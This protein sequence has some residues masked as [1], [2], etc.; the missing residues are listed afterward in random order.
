MKL[1]D[2]LKDLDTREIRAD[3]SLEIRSV[4]SDSRKLRQGDVFVC[5]K[6]T[7]VDGTSF[8]PSA[9]ERGAAA[10]V[11][12][13][14]PKEKIPYVLM[15]DTRDALPRL[16]SN[17]YGHPER[18]F[19]RIIGITGTNGKT[20]T[21]FMLKAIFDHAGHKTGLIGTTKYLVL[22][23]EFQV[24]QKAAFLTT[25][26]PELLFEL[27]C[28]MREK[29]VD[30]VIMETSSHALA[31]QKLAGIPFHVGIFTNL[32]RDHIDFH[33]TMEEYLQAKKLLFKT[34]EKG[35]FNKDDPAFEAIT[36]NVRSEVFSFSSEK[37]AHFKA[38]RILSHTPHGL[39]FELESPEGK[40][41]I[42]LP[43]P[44]LFNI[45]NALCAL[46]GASL[47][48]IPV[49]TAK[50]ALAHMAGV[51]GRI[52]R[53]PTDT[54]FSVFID[55]AHTPD[56]LENIIKT[57]RSFTEGRLMVLFGCGGDRD[58]TKRP[59]MGEIACRLSDFVIV[60]SDNSRTEKK[61]DIIRDILVG[62]EGTKTPLVSI[63]DRTAAI[64][65]AIDEAREGDVILLAGKGH[66]E[67]EIDEN[68]KHDYSEK[69]IVL[70]YIGEK[71]L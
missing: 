46:G 9:L 14:A 18:S 20:T 7:R 5:L 44:G 61:E 35:L 23:E 40:E 26:D 57:L 50:E 45:S 49:K 34:A 69:A 59:I 2:L 68:G 67:Y 48:G 60:T 15:E 58:K 33:Q 19:D 70:E 56:A 42:S 31:L 65:F 38:G 25:P 24:D 41:E 30:T 43:L 54:P 17:L 64:R 39:C 29:G 16:L 36:E 3:L 6:G 11:T 47:C 55:F 13:E 62:T 66:E 37:A 8:I 21:S 71:K 63:T 22:D 1:C 52:E 53:I 12:Y 51:K 27:F 32:T 28:A 4:T 10:V